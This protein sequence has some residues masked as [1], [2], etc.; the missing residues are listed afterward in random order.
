MADT[1]LQ[2][3]NPNAGMASSLGSTSNGTLGS[4]S[5]SSDGSSLL[6][7]IGG[8]ISSFLNSPLGNLAEFGTLAG[9][10]LSQASSAESQ[11]ANAAGQLTSAGAPFSAAGTNVLGQF[12]AAEPGSAAQQTQAA[13]TLGNIANTAFSNYQSGTLS[14]ADQ[15][16]LNA[17]VTAEKQQVAQQ[18][19]NSGGTDTSALDTADQQIDSNA[20]I[21]KQNLLNAQFQTGQQ[22]LTQVQS[23]YTNLLSNALSS[24]EFGLGALSQGLNLQITQDAQITQSLN[25]LFGQIARGFGTAI[26]PGGGGSA[27]TSG[28]GG[29]GGTAGSA[30]GK[31][32]GSLLGGSGF[33]LDPSITG[34]AGAQDAANTASDFAASNTDAGDLATASNQQWLDSLGSGTGAAGA[35]DAAGAGAAD[36][37]GSDIALS[38]VGTDAATADTTVSG[39]GGADAGAGAGL[40]AGV[41]A[42][43]GIAGVLA[44]AIIG[45]ST[46]AVSLG[47]NYWTN[48]ANTLNTTLQSGDKGQMAAQIN[49]LLSMPQNQVPANIQQ[50]VWQTGLVPYGTWGLPTGSPQDVLAL[51]QSSNARGSSGTVSQNRD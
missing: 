35:A 49:G 33:T 21:Q 28:G 11:A 44:P 51:E 23:T 17:M 27:G 31:A 8:G 18:L 4:S 5:G 1:Q 19:A 45:M 39:L 22:A 16:S 40:G 2:T 12:T 29:V 47:Q 24:S 10:G 41:G 13:G 43:A 50:M 48:Y 30:I 20:L 46:P 42:A 34:T 25:N 32:A 14:P 37:A 7:D 36:A 6:G 3:A 38:S 9:L 26:A 15:A